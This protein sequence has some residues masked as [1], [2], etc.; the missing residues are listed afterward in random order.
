MASAIVLAGGSSRRMSGQFKALLNLCGHPMISYVLETAR[1]VAQDIV[2]VVSTAEQAEAL[3]NSG[4]L[5]DVKLVLDEGLGPNCPLLGLVSGL[6]AVEAEKAIVIACDTPL[7]SKTV[8]EFLLDIIS[9]MNAAVPRWPNGFMEPLQAVYKVSRAL[10]AGEELL[11]SGGPYDLRSFLRSLG[12]V[13]YVSTLLLEE[14]DPGLNTF[15]N[16]NT[17]ADLRRAETILRARRACKGR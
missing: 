5:S 4:I 8:L 2:V 12:R 9:R 6:R 14:L 10:R 16:V 13:R 1:S 7:V 3:R 17:L 15:L 11:R